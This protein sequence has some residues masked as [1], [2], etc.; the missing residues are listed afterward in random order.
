MIPKN[1]MRVG[2]YKGFCR[3]SSVA[4]WNGSTFQ[5]M[6]CKF[7]DWF[8]EEIEHFEDV[9]NKGTDGFI[10]IEAIE[11]DYSEMHELKKEV[12]Y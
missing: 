1:E 7:G 3:N 11:I 8:I 2:D 12:G 4:Y 6:R 5:Y 9:K 10:P